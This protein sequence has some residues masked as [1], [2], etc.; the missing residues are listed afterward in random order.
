MISNARTVERR[1]LTRCCV[2]CGY[3]G[4]EVSRRDA[5][6]C[7]QCDCDLTKR[8]A[9]SYAEMEGLLG[10]PALIQP[11]RFVEIDL[12]QD[13]RNERV[14][15]RWLAFLFISMIG[16]LAIAYLAAAVMAV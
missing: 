9:R 1:L 2:R 15:Y 11:R 10:T 5:G 4:P 8:P 3:D 12:A 13:E 16:L 7:P 6:R 14:V